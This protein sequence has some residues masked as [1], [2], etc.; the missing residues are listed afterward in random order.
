MEKQLESRA[1]NIFGSE[2]RSEIKL[3]QK[4]ELIE[5]LYKELGQ[6]TVELEWLKK[7]LELTNEAKLELVKSN[8]LLQLNEIP[9]YRMCELLDLNRSNYYYEPNPLNLELMG[10]ID[11]IHTKYPFYEYP[12]GRNELE[13][14]YSFCV[15]EKRVYRLVQLMGIVAIYPK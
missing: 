14:S 2:S 5:K 12:R 6:K 10:L 3:Q 4:D 11:K 9:M 8:D 1:E 15:N 13:D 7:N